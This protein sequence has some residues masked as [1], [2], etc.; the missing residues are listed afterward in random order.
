MECVNHQVFQSCHLKNTIEDPWE[1]EFHD[2]SIIHSLLLPEELK[3][4]CIY[5]SD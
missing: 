5:L 3:L 2:C 1:S 4:Y